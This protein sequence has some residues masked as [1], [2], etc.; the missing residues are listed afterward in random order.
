M[1]GVIHWAVAQIFLLSV[2]YTPPTHTHT[3]QPLT[4]ISHCHCQKSGTPLCRNTAAASVSSRKRTTLALWALPAPV[5]DSWHLKPPYKSAGGLPL[6][7]L[8]SSRAG[9]HGAITDPAPQTSFN[10]GRWYSVLPGCCTIILQ[11]VLVCNGTAIC[12]AATIGSK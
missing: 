6:P 10:G 5:A 12:T 9:R 3:I 2:A 1:P 11:T 7:S 8:P 4:W